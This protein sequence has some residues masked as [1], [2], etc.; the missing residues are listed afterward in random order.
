MRKV[1]KINGRKIK[2][3]GGTPYLILEAGTN[4]YEHA[5]LRGISF[6][7]AAQEMITEAS[8]I[9]ADAIKFQIFFADKFISEKHDKK[10]YDYIRRHDLLTIADWK[11]IIKFAN[12]SGIT[13]LASIF[14]TDTLKELGHL[15]PAFKVASPDINNVQLLNAINEFEKPV[16]LSTG[17]SSENDVKFALSKLDKCEVII[18]HCSAVYPSKETDY[19]LSNITTLK[20]HFDEN[21]VGYSHH[22]NNSATPL[23]VAASLGATVIEIHYKIYS[24]IKSNDYKISFTSNDIQRIIHEL[25]CIHAMLGSNEKRVNKRE[26]PVHLNGRRSIYAKVNIEMGCSFSNDNVISLRPSLDEA[27]LATDFDLLT[28]RI[29]SQN[30]KKG[31]IIAYKDAERLT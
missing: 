22:N 27:I 16:I 28:K 9:G 12:R 17:A 29:A 15:L 18:M 6:R 2:S 10:A 25:K 7:V 1:I 21:I 3:D 11:K 23:I 13:F 14:D 31:D 24:E 20:K 19:N 4:F 5:D 26:M 30:I 8:R